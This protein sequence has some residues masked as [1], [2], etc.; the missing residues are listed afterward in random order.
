MSDDQS[1]QSKIADALFPVRESRDALAD[2]VLN[3]PLNERRLHTET[4]DFT[5]STIRDLLKENQ[6]KIPEFQRKYVWSR[7]Q[8][9][10]LIESLIIQCPIPVIYLDQEDDGS[11]I[12][13][14]GNQRLMSI[15]LFLSNQ[16]KLRGLTA[17]PDL[18]GLRFRDLDPRFRNHIVN[19]TLRCITILK[20][21]HP[22]I[23]FDVF[24]RLN[25]GSVQLNAQELRHGLYHGPLMDLLDELGDRPIW[26]AMTGIKADKRMRG[27]ELVLRFLALAFDLSKYEKP[28]AEFLNKFARENKNARRADEFSMM[29]DE[30]LAAANH[31]FGSDAFRLFDEQG[32]AENNLNAAVFDAQMVGIARAKVKLDYILNIDPKIFLQKYKA[33]QKE[34]GFNR[35]VTASTSDPPLVA[36]RIKDVSKLLRGN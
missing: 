26:R 12:V 6:I 24:E 7:T 18:N 34:E 13:I 15:S 5:I 3:V 20:E 32:N 17:F 9:S 19:R 31:L 1:D 28:L 4:Y 30:T 11:L 36:R 23:K 14:D 16:F 2:D 21:T 10:K 33:L 35:A 22:Q 8:A 25:T 29:F 27:A